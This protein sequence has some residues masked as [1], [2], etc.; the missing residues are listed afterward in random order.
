[1]LMGKRRRTTLEDGPE[2]ID[3]YVGTRLKVRRLGFRIS[4]TKLGQVTGVTFQQI[5]KYENGMNRIG[6]GNLYK[7]SKALGVE[8]AYF[9]EGV[10]EI[11]GIDTT[12]LGNDFKEDP[13]SNKDTT[14][15]THDYI[16]IKDEHVRKQIFL[17]VKALAKI[18]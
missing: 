5:Q 9:F 11:M 17:L 15:V 6:A 2:P 1:M 18:N 14:R 10:D 12:S 13:M 8:V 3:V 16:R 7:F 4:Q